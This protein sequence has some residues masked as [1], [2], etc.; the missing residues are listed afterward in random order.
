VIDAP[1]QVMAEEFRVAPVETGRLAEVLV[2]PGVRVRQGQVLARMD[3][4][5]L[6]REIAVAEARLKQ[7]GAES[8]ASLVAMESDG[9]QTERSF[10]TDAASL[11]TELESA[12]AAQAAQNSELTHLSAEIERQRQL[13]KDGL[14]RADRMEELELRRKTLADAAAQWPERIA[15][16]AA[17]H[18]EALARLEQWRS[19]HR[20]SLAAASRETRMRPLR[21]R[22]GEQLEALRVLRARLAQAALTAPAAGEVVAVLARPGD[23]VRPDI[24]FVTIHGSG[25]RYLVAYVPEVEGKR[26]KPGAEAVVARRT[27][28]AARHQTKVTRVADAVVQ[29]PQRF[30]LTPTIPQWGREVTLA[31]PAAS[32]FDPGEALTAKLTAG[33]LE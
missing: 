21:D 33:G 3:S 18:R 15:T 8:D 24:P 16:L 7:V 6:E 10:Q 11:A 9:Y 14:T 20:V 29:A 12:R 13:V 19:G 17:R 4:A 27:A 28:D 1:A 22:I 25:P 5:V 26:L 30:W 32:A 31:L 2:T 23:V